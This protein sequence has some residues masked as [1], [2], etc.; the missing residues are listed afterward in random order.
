M[1]TSI[2]PT[3]ALILE[4]LS[5]RGQTSLYLKRDRDWLRTLTGDPAKQVAG[6]KK[7]GTLF[8]VGG[9]RYVTLTPGQGSDPGELPTGTLL[10]AAFADRDDWYLGYL[11]ALIEHRLA[12]EHSNDLF[13]AVFGPL[14]R[15]RQLAGHPLHMTRLT[16]DHK[17][18]GQERV[19]AAGRTF[20]L[21][22]DLERTLLDTLDRPGMCGAPEIWARA[23]SRAFASDQLDR[24]RLVDYALR[25]GGTLAARCAFWMREVG[26]VRDSRLILKSIGAPL[27]GPRVLDAAQS[28]GAGEWRRDRDT[29]LIVNMPTRAIDGWLTY[30]K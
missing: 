8:P 26:E 2:S 10:A 24:R 14:P 7:R 11:S 15:L 28:F 3:D 16:S 6:M 13:V 27:T 19:R 25:V 22:S 30:G 1:P 23:W 18:F 5:Q 4:E 12:D 17:R 21:R 29:G 20:Y 9:G